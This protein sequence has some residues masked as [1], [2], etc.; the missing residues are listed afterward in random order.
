[1]RH[2]KDCFV[3]PMLK[4]FIWTPRNDRKNKWFYL[5]AEFFDAVYLQQNGYDPIDAACSP[6]RQNYIFKKIYNFLFQQLTF[7]DKA[8]AREFFHKLR[9]LYIDWN[10]IEW[11]S[12]K[13]KEQEKV[14]D[15]HIESGMKVES[16]T[17]A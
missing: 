7:K 15:K 17:E 5:K 4:K 1:M 13:F 6:E 3:V 10:Y 12:G 14:I 2:Y 8:E 16:E 11:Q 9:Q